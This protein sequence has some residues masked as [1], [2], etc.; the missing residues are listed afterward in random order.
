MNDDGDAA[1]DDDVDDDQWHTDEGRWAPF[2]GLSR[3]GARV[4]T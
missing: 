1:D 2:C 3:G 4:F